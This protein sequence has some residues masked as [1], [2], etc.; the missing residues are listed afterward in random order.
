[1]GF[2]AGSP[3]V[4]CIAAEVTHLQLCTFQFAVTGNGGFA[5]LYLGGYI[6]QLDAGQTAV[7]IDRKG[8]IRSHTIAVRSGYFVQRVCCTGGQHCI[9]AMCCTVCC[10]LLDLC[11]SCVQELQD[12][13]GQRLAVLIN[14][15]DADLGCNVLHGDVLHLTVRTNN[16]LLICCLGVPLGSR[17][18]SEDICLTGN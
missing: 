13:S 14:L 17:C 7:C 15:V 8:L 2:L 1:M 10:P 4:Q 3:A 16:N 11:A 9:Y 12:C 6:G 18:F 5:D